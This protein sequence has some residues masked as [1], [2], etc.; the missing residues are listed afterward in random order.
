MGTNNSSSQQNQKKLKMYI[1]NKKDLFSL[2]CL[3][4]FNLLYIAKGQLGKEE[5]K[6]LL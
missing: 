4:P 2:V 5:I 1:T 6:A 3:F